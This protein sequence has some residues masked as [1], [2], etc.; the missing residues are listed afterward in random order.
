M[1]GLSIR[2][3]SLTFQFD[4]LGEFIVR[5]V[6]R[7]GLAR[8]GHTEVSAPSIGQIDIGRYKMTTGDSHGI[9][10]MFFSTRSL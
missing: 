6:T 5:I 7:N 10:L 3:R 4:P 2:Q 8:V 9:S 1:F